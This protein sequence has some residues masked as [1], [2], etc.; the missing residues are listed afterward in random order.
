MRDTTPGSAAPSDARQ[1]DLAERLRA[2]RDRLAA[3]DL[4]HRGQ[5]WRLWSVCVAQTFGYSRLADRTFAVTLGREAGLDR[6]AASRLLRRFH[7]LDVFVWE[8]APHGSHAAST[9]R[10]PPQGVSTP[11]VA[12]PQGVSTPPEACQTALSGGTD[13][14][15]HSNE[16]LSQGHDLCEGAPKTP[17]GLE[18]GGVLVGQGTEPEPTRGFLDSLTECDEAALL[19]LLDDVT[20]AEARAIRAELE[21][22]A[23]PPRT[24][25]GWR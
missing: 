24:P 11:P 13:A 16:S 8:A 17:E 1:K 4:A 3:S 6:K 10:L 14:P 2:S 18:G 19:R 23:P 12:V 7:E 15:L 5:A 20:P 22:R 21:G 25:R 9:L